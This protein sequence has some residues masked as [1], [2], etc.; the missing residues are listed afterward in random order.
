MQ[1]LQ[2]IARRAHWCLV[3]HASCW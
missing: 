2:A 1:I 3:L